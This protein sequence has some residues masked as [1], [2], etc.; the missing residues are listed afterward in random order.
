MTAR[1]WDS[2][3][4]YRRPNGS[5]GVRNRIVVMAAADN[6]NP[7]ARAIAAAV[8]GTTFIPATFGRGQLGA[9]LDVTLRAQSGMAGH[10]NVA[11]ALVVSFEM[12][13][14]QRIADR[15]QR[16]G[17]EVTCL[18]L[19]ESG[20]HT[21]ALEVG[22]KIVGQ[23]KSAAERL[24]LE[25]MPVSS[26]V[27]GLE[28]GGSDATSGLVA[29]PVVG[30]I[31]DELVAAGATTVF[32]EPV[33]LI[34]CEPMLDVRAADPGVANEIRRLTSHYAQIADSAGV[35]LV[36]INP[37]ADNI[38]GGLTSIEEKS[39][40]AVAK[41]GTAPIAGV[42]EYAEC[43]PG[44]GLWLMDA[45]AAAVENLTALGAGGCHA[46]LFTSGSVNPSGSAV[47][48]TLKVCANPESCVSM[49]EHVDVDLSDVLGN[50]IDVD[51]AV[52]RLADGLLAVLAGQEPRADR[53][54]YI[55]TRISRI[56]L[57]V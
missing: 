25:P 5:F 20:G 47:S 57:S 44:P 28:C 53:L 55:E 4:G 13:S 30:R 48:P 50:V 31:S 23:M 43:A 42:I 1:Q 3:T 38:A 51:Q 8:E 52:A 11:A 16:L 35:N 10:P 21:A 2:L 18:S 24:V 7:L 9:D 6:V 34:G 36:G 37:T 41:C 12:E 54:G 15:V 22:K 14:A 17:R 32:S 29:N 49:R 46:I 19:L 26:L 33:E 40:G 27:I 45:P 39:L 56:G